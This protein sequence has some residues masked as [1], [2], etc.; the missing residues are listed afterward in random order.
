MKRVSIIIPAYNEEGMIGRVLSEVNKVMKNSN[1]GYE[2]MVIDDGS[3]DG[4]GRI[5]EK[6]G[7]RLI[8][9]LRN[10]G[11][12]AALKTGIRNAKND[13]ILITDADGTYPAKE[14]PQLLKEM[15]DYDMV[16]GART[17]E[18]V[19]MPF[20]R[21]PAK[22]FLNRLASYLSERKIPDINS[23]LRAFKK[24]IALKY[25]HI[26]PPKFSFTTT[27]TLAF[28]SDDYLVKYIPIDYRKRRGRSK[29]RPLRD[30]WAFLLLIIRTIIYFNPLKVLLPLASFL[31]LLGIVVLFY[32]KFVLQ[33]VMDI[34]VILL[35]VTSLLVALLGLIADLIV[36]RSIRE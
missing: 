22:F 23:G 19:R 36:K 18:E 16:V 15:K 29:I 25:F 13:T 7:A 12:G 21:R 3:S 33:Q 9:H 17:G 30:T 8:S 14:I 27:L 34:T 6:K 2:T 11:Y 24:D 31:F 32:S 1:W 35:I 28:L 5:A 26:L 20:F 10:R 4:T